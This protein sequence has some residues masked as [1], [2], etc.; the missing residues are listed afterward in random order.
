M[1]HSNHPKWYKFYR[2]VP[3]ILIISLFTFLANRTDNN[4]RQIKN[5]QHTSC[6]QSYANSSVINEF[7][8]LLITATEKS[9][10]LSPSESKTRADG[11]RKLI[12]K[13]PNCDK[14]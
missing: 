13:I 10:T 4:V 8:D 3:F 7:L 12:I 1:F 11:Y 2:V 6:L 5:T 14:Q 9:T